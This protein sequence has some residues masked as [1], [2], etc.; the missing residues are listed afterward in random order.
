[1]LDENVPAS[2]AARLVGLG[3]NA[4]FIRDHTPAGSP[5]QLVATVSEEMEAILVSFDGDFQKIAPRIPDGQRRRFRNLSRI[6]MRCS[7]PEA[8]ARV[9]AAINLIRSEYDLAQE[10]ADCRMQ[11]RIGSSY[12]RTER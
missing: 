3:H 10:R 12:L 6:W 9:E 2:V 7:E 11:L 1:M 8:A 4:L 5:D